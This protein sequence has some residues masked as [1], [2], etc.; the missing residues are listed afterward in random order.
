M[1]ILKYIVVAKSGNL[2]L[3]FWGFFVFNRFIF[4]T[5]LSTFELLVASC[6]DASLIYCSGQHKEYYSVVRS[7]ILIIS[8]S[9]SNLLKLY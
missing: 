2:C 8:C 6:N 9:S 3:R 5:F 1:L 7:F 4:L